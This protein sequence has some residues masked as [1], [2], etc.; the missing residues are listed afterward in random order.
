MNKVALAL[1]WFG[2]II[3]VGGFVFGAYMARET[4]I[5]ESAF[6]SEFAKQLVGSPHSTVT[7]NFIT[8]AIYWFTAGVSAVLLF[9]IAEIIKLL[10]R[11]SL[12][13]PRK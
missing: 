6:R 13:L 10:E 3:I 11:I 12:E 1:T 2:W 8:A 9:G 5:L 7:F 4:H